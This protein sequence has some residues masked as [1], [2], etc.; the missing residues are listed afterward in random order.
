M[1]NVYFLCR[2]KMKLL[3]LTLMLFSSSLV[4]AINYEV[5]VV[6]IAAASDE[7][8]VKAFVADAERLNGLHRKGYVTAKPYFNVLRMTNEQVYFVF[9]FRDKVQGIVRSKYNNT[10]K[11][12]RKIRKNSALQYPT[13]YWVPVEE[14]RR[15][16]LKGK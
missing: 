16:L 3:I 14:I 2:M 12:L 4:H 6:G 11:N 7:A 8:K 15:L 5:L 13:P 10:V 9:G 1:L